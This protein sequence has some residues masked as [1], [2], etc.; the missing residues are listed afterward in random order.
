MAG[1]L[2]RAKGAGVVASARTNARGIARFV[3][4]APRLGIIRF[5]GTGPRSAAGTGPRCRTLVG[6]L[7]PH[8]PPP[9]TG[10]D[11]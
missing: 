2:V 3:F 11:G 8:Q 6:V 10:R 9:L 4:T 1:I 5:T 7:P